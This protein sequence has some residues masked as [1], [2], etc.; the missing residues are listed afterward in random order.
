MYEAHFGFSGPPFQLNPDPSFYFNSRGH[1]H[2]LAYLRYGAAQGEG[3]IVVT[4]EIGAGKTTLVRTLLD[5]LD[6][7]QIVPAQIVSTQLAEGELLQAILAAY[8]I[9][10]Q[11]TSKA[12]LLATLEAF[13]MALATQGRR[14]LLIVDEAQNLQT[15]VIEELRMLS[16]FQL[17]TH[18]LMQSFLVGQPELRKKLES[19]EL[20]QFRQR[21]TA[22]CHLGPLDEAETRAYVEHRLHRVGWDGQ[23]PL[24]GEG[25]FTQVHRW[26]G[27]VPR[28]IN[29]LCNRLLLGAFLEA[30]DEITAEQVERTALE[31]RQEIGETFEPLPLGPSAQVAA[32]GPAPAPSAGPSSDIDVPLELGEVAA[33]VASPTPAPAPVVEPVSAPTVEPVVAAPI[34]APEPI[35]APVVTPAVAPAVDVPVVA[36]VPATEAPP[37]HAPVPQAPAE[38][39]ATVSAPAPVAEP[40]VVD[41][42]VYQDALVSISSGVSAPADVVRT[43]N[44]VLKRG[45]GVLLCLADTAAGALKAAA[46]AKALAAVDGAPRMLL[47]NPGLQ[48]DVWPWEDMESILPA[49][50]VG[51]HLGVPTGA[52]DAVAPMLFER[53][54]EVIQEFAPLGLLS[55]GSSEAV[56]ACSLMA[57][58]RGIP[59]VRIEAGERQAQGEAPLNALLIEQIAEMLFA[60]NVPVT[61]RTLH[62]MGVLPERVQGVPGR[63]ASDIQAAVEPAM[64]TPYGAFLRNN[65]PMFLGPRW[66]QQVDG[67]AYAVVALDAHD[68]ARV[69][70]LLDVLLEVHA[71]TKLV[72]LVNPSTAAVLQQWL[73]AHPERADKVYLIPEGRLGRQEVE[74]RNGASILCG[75]V[76]SLPDQFSILRGAV[77]L[78]SEPSQLLADVAE[79][80]NVPA[81]IVQGRRMTLLDHGHLPAD[82]VWG[83]IILNDK[84][85]QLVD[86]S[87]AQ[88]QAA[89]VQGE[90]GQDPMRLAPPKTESPRL[91]PAFGIAQR[92]Q[93]WVTVRQVAHRAHAQ[94]A[95]QAV[96]TPGE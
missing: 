48:A 63:L 30:H 40:V 24:F 86:R 28:R 46:I 72:W 65:L 25:A 85:A 56:L 21:V 64:T 88:A 31:L 58:K 50:E 37:A 79:G 90:S 94:G 62:Q 14:A 1:G 42:Q 35:E 81:L 82:H 27:G 11:G 19:P 4:G 71:V 73:T 68:P 61:H 2:A 80:F 9:P 32:V 60:T 84:I 29:R 67:T 43:Q 83:S 34:P 51:L 8:G 12:S 41:E 20:E 55:L 78:I 39:V 52:F 18:A 95:A 10:S 13:L 91:S 53:L 47:V 3:F 87:Q 6:R 89:G 49:L 33:P 26:T 75:Q 16:N 36:E 74:E 70:A 45:Y 7:V 54:D 69:D 38:D 93:G 59:V 5:E 77:C 92:L 22:S 44:L 66:S 76:R 23:R 57:H 15:K 17:G 96:T